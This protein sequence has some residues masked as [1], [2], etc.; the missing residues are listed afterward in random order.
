[1]L[2]VAPTARDAQLTQALFAS[3]GLGCTI[4][5]DLAA[6]RGE[7]ARGAGALVLTEEALA[8][9]RQPL[10]RAALSSQ[11]TWSDLPIILLAGVGLQ[12]LLS[13][14]LV[15]DLGNV[16]VL[17]RPISAQTLL[18]AVRLALRTRRRQY[19]A[20]LVAEAGEL[21][22][23]ALGDDA[24]L[25][26]VAALCVP[27]L[28]DCCM[29]ATRHTGAMRLAATVTAPDE[30]PPR[31]CDAIP[32]VASFP[33][34][35]AATGWLEQRLEDLGATATVVV[36]LRSRGQT[37][38]ALGLAMLNAGRTFRGHDRQVVQELADRLAPAL[39][40]AQLYRAEQTARA[41]AEAAVQAR[42]ELVALISHDLNNP[43]TTV[44]GQAQLL[45]RQLAKEPLVLEKI[46]RAVEGVERGARQMQAQ[47]AELLDTAR[48]RAG[49]PLELRREPAD[50][51]TL[52]REAVARIQQT[53]E[54][55]TI[56]VHT[57]LVSLVAPV[58]LRRIERVFDNLLSNAVKY[59]PNGGTITA[60][61]G[62]ER[63]GAE[64]WAVVQVRDQGVGIP[65][66][67][68]SHIFEHFRRGANV[69]GT[70]QGTGLGLASTRQIVGQHGGHIAVASEVGAGSTFTVRLPHVIELTEAVPP[71]QD[72]APD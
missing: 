41:A 22:A 26:A 39:G 25:A 23:G 44:L 34:G 42:D 10:V 40:Q 35:A 46:S 57:S 70:T 71:R 47:I 1:M 43:L 65:E 24:T 64:V 14:P 59:S 52:T 11:P 32:Q 61:I 62:A 45:K 48:L 67:E 72:G 30:V 53:T 49:Q 13:A 56:C 63:D 18:H 21:L 20:R 4:C 51:V 31:T 69:I 15:Q 36:P 58:D 7:L 9:D 5:Q 54:R 2:V 68:L 17:E 27:R 8:G 16:L 19:H 37:L 55:H 38:G 29:I 6:L 12:P 3:A 66:A 50:L 33:E 60:T 28:A